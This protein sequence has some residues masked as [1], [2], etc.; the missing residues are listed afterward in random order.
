MGNCLLA[1]GHTEVVAE[2][3]PHKTLVAMVL[4]FFLFFGRAAWLVG[5]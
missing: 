4:F 5:F 2:L 3:N 1:Q